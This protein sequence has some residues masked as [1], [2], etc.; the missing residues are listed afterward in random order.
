MYTEMYLC[1]YTSIKQISLPKAIFFNAWK[2]R[3]GYCPYAARKHK[4][5]RRFK[6]IGKRKH[7]QQD[8]RWEGWGGIAMVG[9]HF[10]SQC[11]RTG[12]MAP[13]GSGYTLSLGWILTYLLE[14]NA[15]EEKTRKLEA[16]YQVSEKPPSEF[17][18]WQPVCFVCS[19]G[20]LP[21][22]LS[23]NLVKA[24]WIIVIIPTFFLMKCI[25]V[26][27]S[28]TYFCM[29]SQ[30]SA[31]DSSWDTKFHAL[32][33]FFNLMVCCAL[34][35]SQPC[36]ESPITQPALI[37]HTS[38][39]FQSE[40]KKGHSLMMVFQNLIPLNSPS[41]YSS[42]CPYIPFFPPLPVHIH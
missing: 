12:P 41:C 22:T 19:L 15:S 7:S 36:S 1:V 39:A 28:R 32:R 21:K 40:N 30:R 4:L 27:L 31:R 37:P 5:L 33:C 11:C 38:L 16:F 8:V 35:V 9:L 17:A 42:Q 20:L 29:V 24:V 13:C 23:F 2:R 26:T 25:K 34:L 6:S 10:P 3:I 14:V 18:F